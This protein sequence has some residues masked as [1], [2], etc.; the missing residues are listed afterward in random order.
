MST[1]TLKH[2][3]ASQGTE[4]HWRHKPRVT[5]DKLTAMLVDRNHGEALGRFRE[6]G[7]EYYTYLWYGGPKT[8]LHRLD[9]KLSE[10]TL[11]EW[12][13]IFDSLLNTAT[14]LNCTE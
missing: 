3:P 8:F 10:A 1:Q 4:V 13:G 7:R 9:V 2:K 11:D 14:H 6:S 5:F 12:S